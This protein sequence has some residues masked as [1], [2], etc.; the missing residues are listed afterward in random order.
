MR[1]WRVLIGARIPIEGAQVRV[2]ELLD[3]LKPFG[4]TVSAYD[5]DLSVGLTLEAADVYDAL[6]RAFAAVGTTLPAGLITSIAAET[7]QP[8][9]G[10]REDLG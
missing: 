9:A 7:P 4:G 5:H 3:R 8:T 10:E 6:A 2:D 1:E